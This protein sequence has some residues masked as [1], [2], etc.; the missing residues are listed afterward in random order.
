[1]ATLLPLKADP[2]RTPSRTASGHGRGPSTTPEPAH[3]SGAT[4]RTA[5]FWSSNADHRRAADL[6]LRGPCRFLA[7]S[8]RRHVS[9]P[10]TNWPTRLIPYCGRHGLHPYRIHARSPSIPYDP[11]WGYQTTG[12]YA[13]TARF[14][15]P[16]GFARFVNGCAQA[17]VVGVILDWVP[18]H[19]PDRTRMAWRHFDGTALYEHADPRQGFHPDWNTAIYNFG[20]QRGPVLPD[21]QRALLGRE[22]PSRRPARRCRR[23]DA[24]PRLFPQG[25]RVDPQRDMAAAKTWRR[26]ASSSR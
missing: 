8:R 16:E 11:S 21:Q 12:L 5:S 17:P 9:C 23:L 2:L 7:A 14:G 15:E 22:I 3:E 19:F 13:P 20:R 1:M 24:L 6:D 4:R 26:C 18:A 25:R 10:G